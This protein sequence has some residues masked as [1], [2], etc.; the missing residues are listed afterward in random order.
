MVKF[1]ILLRKRKDMSFED[2]VAYHKTNHAPLFSSL[3]EVKQ[4]V[5]KYVQ[6][7][8]IPLSLPG[9]PPPEYDGITELWFDQVEDIGKLFGSE[10][11]LRIIRPDEAKILDL[12]GCGFLVSQ[13]NPVFSTE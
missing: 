10:P 8:T 9:L 4:Y 5:R 3:P 1:T 7:H 13:E 11:Y 12:A 2:F 6:C